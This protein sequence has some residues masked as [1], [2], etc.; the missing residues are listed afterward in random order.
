MKANGRFFGVVFVLNLILGLI[1]G[2]I[3]LGIN[4]LA[5]GA[6]WG[7]IVC[8]VLFAAIAVYV[9]LF[10]VKRSKLKVGYFAYGTIINLA[11]FGII[12]ALI[13]LI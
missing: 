11:V 12:S 7:I 13:M 8:G 2:L 3:F 9:N 5:S 4:A 1:G 10:I 6:I